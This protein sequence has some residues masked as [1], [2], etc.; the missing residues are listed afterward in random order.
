MDT[1]HDAVDGA[2]YKQN[3]VERK[4]QDHISVD[5]VVILHTENSTYPSNIPL[6]KDEILDNNT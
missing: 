3:A 4:N 5:T 2:L 1:Q 6:D